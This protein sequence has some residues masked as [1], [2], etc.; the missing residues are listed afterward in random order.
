MN[1]RAI[2]SLTEELSILRGRMAELLMAP[3][4]RD[5][6]ERPGEVRVNS[7]RI[8]PTNSYKLEIFNDNEK[9]GFYEW[10]EELD[11]GL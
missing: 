7:V 3:E 11:D 4:P 9:G 2:G 1:A 5:D 6:G 10:R 8:P